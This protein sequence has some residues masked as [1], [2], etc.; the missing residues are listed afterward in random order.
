M[1]VIKSKCHVREYEEYIYIRIW[2]KN[3]SWGFTRAWFN[4]KW[5]IQWKPGSLTPKE[6]LVDEREYREGPQ[7]IPEQRDVLYELRLKELG[8]IKLR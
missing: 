7:N 6:T 8:L 5:N 3:F 4:P 1:L 2:R